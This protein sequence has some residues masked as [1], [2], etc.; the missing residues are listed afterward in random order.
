VLNGHIHQ[1][2]QKVEGHVSFH[3]ARS[4]AYPQPAPGTAAQPG[5]QTVPSGELGK[6]LGTRRVSVVRGSHELAVVD[7]PLV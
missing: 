1:V 7:A 4:T 5:P 3:T 2:M 6:V